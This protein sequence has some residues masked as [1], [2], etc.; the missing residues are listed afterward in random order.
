MYVIISKCIKH[1]EQSALVKL[2]N[3]FCAVTVDVMY[4]A[5]GAGERK[6]ERERE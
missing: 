2:A 5:D 6:R 3:W 1:K 4:F